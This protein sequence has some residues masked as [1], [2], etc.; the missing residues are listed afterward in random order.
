MSLSVTITATDPGD[1]RRKLSDMLSSMGVSSAPTVVKEYVA[2]VDI[3]KG[4]AVKK[5]DPP[6][7]VLEGEVLEPET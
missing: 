2:T 3:Q 5:V 1:L 6:T 7:E 4:D